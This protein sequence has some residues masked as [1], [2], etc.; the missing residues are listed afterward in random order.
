MIF[1][2]TGL[3]IAHVSAPGSLA[4]T[5]I[6]FKVENAMR[7]TRSVQIVRVDELSLFFPDCSSLPRTL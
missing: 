2:G 1:S 7:G 4:M 5:Q 3:S 6:T